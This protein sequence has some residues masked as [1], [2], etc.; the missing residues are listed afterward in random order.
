MNTLAGSQLKEAK[1]F[2]YGRS[3]GDGARALESF[4]GLASGELLDL[5]ASMNPVAPSY[6]RYL[7]DRIGSLNSYPDPGAAAACLAQVLEVDEA[8]LVLCNGGAEAIQL[9][10]QKVRTGWVREPDFSLYRRHISRYDL[11]GP[12]WA[13][14]PN[15]PAGTL[16]RDSEVPHVVEIGN[17]VD[18]VSQPAAN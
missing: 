3:H 17:K 8:Q 9:V 2:L 12:W 13:S 18:I 15:N 14:N 6:D 7:V 11:Q 5:S 4:L 1:R 10:S 16:L